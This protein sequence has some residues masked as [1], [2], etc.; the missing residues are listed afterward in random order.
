[1][2]LSFFRDFNEAPGVVLNSKEKKVLNFIRKSEEL[3]DDEDSDKIGDYNLT[4]RIDIKFQKVKST[5]GI[6]VKLTNDINNPNITIIEEDISDNYPWDY[7]VLYTRLSKRYSDFKVNS[8]FHNIRKE[9]EGNTKLAHVRFLN[10][11]NPKGGKKIL[12]NP[13]IVK[14]F[15]KHYTLITQQ[16]ISVL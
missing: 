10:P 7:D 6:P 9:L 16:S 11:K 1:M 15:D 8:K 4:L 13:N 14:E 5:S 12:F 2:P 3:Y